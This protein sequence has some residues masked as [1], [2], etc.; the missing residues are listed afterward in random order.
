M[1]A[2]VFVGFDGSA[3]A[4]LAVHAA[5]EI[6][7]R[8]HSTL[9]IA[10]VRSGGSTP[11]DALLESLVPLPEGGKAFGAVVDEVRTKAVAEGA[12]GVESVILEGEVLETLLHWISHHHPDLV[13][14]GSRGLSRGRRLLLGS[15]SSGLVNRAPCPVLVVRA[16]REHHSRGVGHGA[17]DVPGPSSIRTV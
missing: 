7:T 8:F 14:V 6:A 9:T 11:T 5:T 15:V 13:V 10:I 3:P 16:S 1:F 2:R 17:T 12:A 4:R